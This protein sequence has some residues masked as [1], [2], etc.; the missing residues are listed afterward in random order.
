MNFPQGPLMEQISCKFT[1]SFDM[2]IKLFH[3]AVYI[4]VRSSQGLPCVET[5]LFEKVDD[6]IGKKIS[7]VQEQE[8]LVETAKERIARVVMSNSHGPNR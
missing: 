4:M 2:T 3:E 6:L 1:P 7:S 8:E 5:C